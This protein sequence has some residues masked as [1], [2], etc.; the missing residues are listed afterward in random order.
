MDLAPH[1]KGL[2]FHHCRQ[3]RGDGQL[4]Q[5]GDIMKCRFY[6][7]FM[8]RLKTLEEWKDTKSR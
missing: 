1:E 3:W 2:R 8:G 6:D 5:K 7:N 4:E